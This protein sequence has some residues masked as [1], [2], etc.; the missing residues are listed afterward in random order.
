MV[1]DETK[2]PTPALAS[3]RTAVAVY[4]LF[5]VCVCV[6]D[7]GFDYMTPARP[8]QPC[9]IF[10]LCY[11]GVVIPREERTFFFLLSL[12]LRVHF[13]LSSLYSLLY[14]NSLSLS[15]SLRASG[16][17]RRYIAAS[18]TASYIDCYILEAVV[19][20]WR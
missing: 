10:P 20:V 13:S 4:L 17:Y 19:R 8:L 16:L 14:T 3:A 1:Y 6:C 7:V 18:R 2:L 12:S 9:C 15:G 5:G 11:S